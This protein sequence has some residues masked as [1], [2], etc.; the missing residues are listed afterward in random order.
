MQNDWW[1][2]VL[3]PFLLCSVIT[4]NSIGSHNAD[5]ESQLPQSFKGTPCSSREGTMPLAAPN[6]EMT[7]EAEPL[8]SLNPCVSQ[9]GLHNR[10]RCQRPPQLL[11]ITI[12]PD[13]VCT[14]PR[15]LEVFLMYIR[16]TFNFAWF[17]FYLLISGVVLYIFFLTYCLPSL[18]MTKFVWW[19]WILNW[20]LLFYKTFILYK[21]SRLY[22]HS[23]VSINFGNFYFHYCNK[24]KVFTSFHLTFFF[25]P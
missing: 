5:K 1:R 22:F 2:R 10:S 19:Y 11:K 20:I 25:H 17:E 12:I 6:V 13:S 15:L 9:K 23:V 24:F 4:W 3:G 16:N 14:V 8:A 7:T 21:S 18:F